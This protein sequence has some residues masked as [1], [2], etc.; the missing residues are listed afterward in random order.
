[1]G[2]K[3]NVFVIGATNRPDIIDTALM[4]PGRLDQLIYI[5]MPDYESRLSILTAVLRKTPVHK[6]VDLQYLATQTD[7][8]TGADLTEIC[9]RSAKLA[10]REDIE[11]NM[12]RERIQADAREQGLME[13]DV[14]EEDLV[15]EIMPRHFENAVRD[16]RRSVSDNDLA[17][18][19]R[20]AQNLQQ[21]RSQLSTGGGSLGTF[22][23]PQAQ[24]NSGTG[25]PAGA[26][27]EE[28][29]DLYS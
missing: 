25:A 23:F 1:V 29:D 28:E 13:E 21:S 2:S 18:Y 22:S 11:R 9:Q 3:K 26:A 4:R 17:Q 19:S 24:N 10:I 20:F 14:E 27:D 15:P 16:A 8:F 5:P 6:D 7:K 12:E